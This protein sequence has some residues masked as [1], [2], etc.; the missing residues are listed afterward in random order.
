MISKAGQKIAHNDKQM[1]NISK[2][3]IE[4]C[5]FIVRKQKVMLDADL[6]RIYCVQTKNLN[7]AVKRNPARFPSDFMF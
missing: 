2:T 3:E 5:I 6:A 4:K 7:K 1:T